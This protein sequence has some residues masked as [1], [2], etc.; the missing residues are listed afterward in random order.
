MA[1]GNKIHSVST[2]KVEELTTEE[3]LERVTEKPLTDKDKVTGQKFVK[4]EQNLELGMFY[5][6]IF[7]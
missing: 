4:I 3:N 5:L 7:Y 6:S 2:D 1:I